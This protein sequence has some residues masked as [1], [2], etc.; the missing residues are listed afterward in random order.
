[1]QSIRFVSLLVELWLQQVGL[2]NFILFCYE[3]FTSLAM[4]QGEFLD[5]FA[6]QKI[7]SFSGL[8]TFGAALLSKFVCS[9]M[10]YRVSC[11]SHSWQIMF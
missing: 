7:M 5:T 9:G 8:T 3:L 1:M 10:P 4:T 6:A 11:H 2:F